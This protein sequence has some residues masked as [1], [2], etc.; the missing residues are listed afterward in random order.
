MRVLIVIALLAGAAF[1]ILFALAGLAR[2]LSRQ[3]FQVGPDLDSN[4]D[5]ARMP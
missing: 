1:M 5:S 2:D 4:E 3:S